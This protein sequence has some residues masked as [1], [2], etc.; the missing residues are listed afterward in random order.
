MTQARSTDHVERA[1][2]KIVSFPT[3]FTKFRA[4]VASY[5]RRWQRVENMAWGV[6]DELTIDTGTGIVLDWIGTLVGRGRGTYVDDAAYRVALRAQIAVNR[7]RGRVAEIV[8]IARLSTSGGVLTIRSYSPASYI[9]TLETALDVAIDPFLDVMRTCK[10]IGVRA[11]VSVSPRAWTDRLRWGTVTDAATG[12]NFGT[13]TDAGI[14][15][16]ASHTRDLS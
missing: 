11:F 15:A 7:S 3:A 2:E 5:A 12:T 16:F 9:A 1:D 6:L 10:P 14:G 8:E 4:L 13:E